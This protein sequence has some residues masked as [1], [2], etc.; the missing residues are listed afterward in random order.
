MRDLLAGVS[1][2]GGCLTTLAGGARPHRIKRTGYR[3]Y[4]SEMVLK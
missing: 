3:K 2:T 1:V 4:P